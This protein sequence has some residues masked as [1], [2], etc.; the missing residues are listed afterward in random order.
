MHQLL[1]G[2]ALRSRVGSKVRSPSVCALAA[3]TVRRQAPHT[4]ANL[5]K[6]VM[7]PTPDLGDTVE[8]SQDA[9]EVFCSDCKG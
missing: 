8:I 6:D 2:F 9:L 7:F 4:L 1:N 3:N 5:S